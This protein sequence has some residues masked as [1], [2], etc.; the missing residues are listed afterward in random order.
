MVDH[1]S[2]PSE[3]HFGV[4][5][6]L[7]LAGLVPFIL[8]AS[9]AFLVPLPWQGLFIQAFLYYSALI[10]SFLGGIHWGVGMSLDRVNSPGFNARLGISV[11]PSLLAWPALFLDV[12]YATLVL[13]GGFLFMRLYERQRESIEL[14]PVWYRS[15]RTWLTAIVVL[16]HLAIIVRV[17]ML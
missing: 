5:H 9:G 12:R 16:A 1:Y 10:L 14:L 13:M 11:V 15:L 8:G 2:K 17:S 6:A 4:A 3:K 7:G